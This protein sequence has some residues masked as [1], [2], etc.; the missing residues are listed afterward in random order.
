MQKCIFHPGFSAKDRLD[1]ILILQIAAS[2]GLRRI[3]TEL[4]A[5]LYSAARLPKWP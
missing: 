1:F 5:K 2:F 3:R 4:K